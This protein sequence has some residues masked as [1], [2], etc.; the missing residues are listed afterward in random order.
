MKGVE[1]L[2]YIIKN[3]CLIFVFEICLYTLMTFNISA[4]YYSNINLAILNF[5]K[6]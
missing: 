1:N 4:R 3:S 5:K 6:L 2:S